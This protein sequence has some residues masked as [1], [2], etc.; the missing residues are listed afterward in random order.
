MLIFFY[1]KFFILK[2]DAFETICILVQSCKT[3]HLYNFA[4]FYTGKKYADFQI[5]VMFSKIF[6]KEMKLF[7]LLANFECIAYAPKRSIVK[8]FAKRNCTIKTLM[9][10]NIYQSRFYCSI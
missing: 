5:E 7:S 10:K 8:H 1:N 6:K 2:S 4:D 9:F 3:V